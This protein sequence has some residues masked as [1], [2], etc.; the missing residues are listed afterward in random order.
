MYN[1]LCQ[2]AVKLHKLHYIYT[3]T[4][5]NF[6]FFCHNITFYIYLKTGVYFRCVRLM[7]C[8]VTEVKEA[9]AE[10]LFVLCK[11]NG[12]IDFDL[13]LTLLTMRQVIT[14]VCHGSFGLVAGDP[15]KMWTNIQRIHHKEHYNIIQ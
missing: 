8:V 6:T 4:D 15:T 11:E 14:W 3:G 1:V 7:T 12:K 13:T 2:L 10:F 9:A 5:T